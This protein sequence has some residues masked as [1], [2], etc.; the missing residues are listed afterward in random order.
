VDYATR[1]PEAVALKKTTIAIA[2]ALVSIFARV[3]VPDE[4]LS[5]KGTQLTSELMKEV[6]RLL[7]VKQLTTTPYHPQC[8]GL[9]ER[10][11]GTLKTML[12]RMCSERPQDWDQY[13]D[14]LLFAYRE[15]PQESLD[16]APFEMLYGRSVK[17]PLQILRQLWTRKQSDPEVR[18]TYQYVVDLRNRLEETWE[19][20][21]EEMKKQQGIQ[22][23]QF[24][25]RAKDRT[26]KHGDLVLILLP[27]SD[28]KLLMQWKGPFKVLERVDGL[29]YRIQVG[30]KQKIFHANMLKQYF[31]A[32]SGE[33]EDVLDP[34]EQ[35]EV[36]KDT[37]EAM[38]VQAVLF[39]RVE[40]S[41]DQG[42]ELETLNSLQ[43]E[44]VKDV[45]INPELS[46]AQQ[47]EV[48]TLLEQYANI[49]TDVP[50]VTNATEHVIELTTA[51]PIK[52][53][54]Y[55]LPHSLRET[56]SKEIDNMLAMGVIEESTAAYASP[57]VIV[58][59]PD[60]SKRVCVDY[61][62][63]N[64]VTIF[65][66]EPM[67]TVEEIFAKLAG[68]QFFLKF[69]LSKGC[70]QLGKSRCVKR[71]GTLPRLSATK[72]SSDSVL[73][74]LA[75]LMLQPHLAVFLR[76]VLRNTQSLDNYL[77]DVLTHMP[78]WKQHLTALR[79]FFQCI[80]KANLTLRPSKC[81]I[82]E[83]TVSFLGHTLTKGE[84]KPRAETIEKIQ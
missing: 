36:P 30:R 40:N 24:D 46:E 61:R 37:T 57:V 83:T 49:F 23:R 67:P 15:A 82:G 80:W 68:D 42:A 78:N 70:W 3:G 22:K 76:R 31:S 77:D 6:G 41:E 28:N 59:K 48:R 20:A 27:T 8:N 17:G 45:K 50:S 25:S 39:E 56:L 62:K 71:I 32:D 74:L 21:H 34:T 52:G 35:E 26:F 43:K 1:Y 73:C 65:D 7:S 51:E 33:P 10:F 53:K 44:T 72:D 4:I 19:M 58:K 38:K 47:A 66:P 64:R 12:K 2:E 69:D 79:Q 13:L 84:T 5:D 55:P 18:T 14:A 60:R 75:W 16:F 29:H 63:L 54:D 9:V 81:E 11:N